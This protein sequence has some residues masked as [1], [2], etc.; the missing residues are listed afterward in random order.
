MILAHIS[1]K[2]TNSL[3]S[4]QIR[5]VHKTNKKNIFSELLAF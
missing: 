1:Q 2:P 4:Q 5:I 3:S